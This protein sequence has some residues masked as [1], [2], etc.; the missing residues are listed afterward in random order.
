MAN[1]EH[2]TS[3]PAHEPIIV[4]TREFDAPRELVWQAWSDPDHVAAWYAPEGF[5]VPRIEL[6]FRPGGVMELDMQGPDG[7]IYPNTA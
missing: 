3:T 5:T 7:T 6:D 1:G 2:E 4:I